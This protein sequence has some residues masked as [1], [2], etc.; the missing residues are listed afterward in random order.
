MMCTRRVRLL[1]LKL[2]WVHNASRLPDVPTEGE[3][4]DGSTSETSTSKLPEDYASWVWSTFRPDGQKLLEAICTCHKTSKAID[5]L[6]NIKWLVLDGLLRTGEAFY[7]EAKKQ[8]AAKAKAKAKGKAGTHVGGDGTPWTAEPA[9][10][11]TEKE[12]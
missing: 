12:E 1:F 11:G 5:V 4:G 9:G 10:E 2:E 7:E 8:P 6:R 3:L